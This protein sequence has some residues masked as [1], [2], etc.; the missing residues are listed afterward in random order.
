MLPRPAPKPLKVFSSAFGIAPK[1][2]KPL[3]SVVAT[4][5]KVGK[6][7]DSIGIIPKP[8]AKG[9]GIAPKMSV[10][11]AF[12]V[13]AGVDDFNGYFRFGF[14]QDSLCFCLASFP[15]LGAPFGGRKLRGC[16][17]SFCRQDCHPGDAGLSS[18]DLRIAEET[19]GQ[20]G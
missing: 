13:E 9:V 7:S 18:E 11:H 16:F 2:G 15:A 10:L 12:S 20:H 5:S 3:T 1:A 19:N 14:D 4:D 17:I 6:P 8:P